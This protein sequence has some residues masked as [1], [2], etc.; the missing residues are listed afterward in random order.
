MSPDFVPTKTRKNSG[1]N[2]KVK[3]FHKGQGLQISAIGQKNAIN[4]YI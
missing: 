1:F 3:E 2:I 4:L